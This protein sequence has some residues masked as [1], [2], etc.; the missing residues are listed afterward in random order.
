[1]AFG[2]TKVGA[3]AR[4]EVVDANDAVTVRQQPVYQRRPD[5]SGR[6]GDQCPHWATIPARGVRTV[7]ESE[8]AV[9]GSGATR[10]SMGPTHRRRADRA[11]VG[12]SGSGRVRWLL[13]LGRPD[14]DRPG[15]HPQ[16]IVR[17]VPVR[18]P[19]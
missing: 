2:L 13:L 10:E 6:A 19:R 1:M 16:P 3:V 17:V 4:A 15:G 8:S 9:D 11:A 14:P 18:R 7:V 5:E 12:R